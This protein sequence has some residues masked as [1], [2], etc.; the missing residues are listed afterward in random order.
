MT[1][2]LHKITSAVCDKSRFV[3]MGNEAGELLLVSFAWQHDFEPLRIS[4]VYMR[5]CGAY[6]QLVSLSLYVRGNNRMK[7]IFGDTHFFIRA[8]QHGSLT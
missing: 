2:L 3:D 7:K 5:N 1:I 8:K 4:Y 6:V